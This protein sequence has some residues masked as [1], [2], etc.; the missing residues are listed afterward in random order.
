V[1]DAT[2]NRLWNVNQDHD[3][4]SVVDAT[5]LTRIAEHAV[6]SAP[7][8]LARAPD[9]AKYARKAGRTIPVAI[10]RPAERTDQI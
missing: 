2:T 7:R 4:V 3:S 10:L 6:G 1:F 8:M 5:S 9:V